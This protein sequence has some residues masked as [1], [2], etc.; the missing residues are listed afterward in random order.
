MN[1]K[2]TL[3]GVCSFVVV[4]FFQFTLLQILVIKE[5]CNSFPINLVNSKAKLGDFE[6]NLEKHVQFMVN[7]NKVYRVQYMQS[8]K[9]DHACLIISSHLKQ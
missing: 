9:S 1:V 8:Q 5:S 6:R 7:Y 3:K 2:R 4:A